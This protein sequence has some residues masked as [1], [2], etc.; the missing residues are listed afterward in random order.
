MSL[1]NPIGG[2]GPGGLAKLGTGTLTLNAANDYAGA[3]TVTAGTLVA[4]V[5]GALPKLSALVLETS[6]GS[7]VLL[8]LGADQSVGRLDSTS[9]FQVGAA[10]LD[11]G[12]HQLTFGNDNQ[13]GNIYAAIQG[14]GQLVKVGSGT[15]NFYNG[16]PANGPVTNYTGSLAVNGGKFVLNYDGFFFS[17]P[18]ALLPAGTS[19]SLGGGTLSVN[20]GSVGVSQAFSGTTINPGAGGLVTGT[21]SQPSQIDLGPLTRSAAG[22]TVDF[23]SSS[24]STFSTRTANTGGAILGGWAT[25]GGTQFAV[26]A[27]DGTNAGAISGLASG[28]GS[29]A[30]GGNIDA[31]GTSNVASGPIN[32]LRFNS[33]VTTTVDATSGLSIQTGGILVTSPSAGGA[34]NNGT[35]TSGNGAD[36]IATVGSFTTLTIGSRI[37]GAIGLTKSGAGTLAVSNPGNDFAGPVTLNAGALQV[38]ASGALAGNPI[39]INGSS[40][41]DRAAPALERR[42]FGQ[43]DLDQRPERDVWPGSHRGARPG[44]AQWRG[45]DH[46]RCAGDHRHQHLLGSPDREWSDP[47]AGWLRG[48]QPGRR[49]RLRRGRKLHRPSDHERHEQPRRRQWPEHCGHARSRHHQLRCARAERL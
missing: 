4:N 36:L 35:L 23:S 2:G 45:H 15:T 9:P 39:T 30:T 20:S 32:S 5:P 18:A 27:G 42:G 8:T 31:S 3:T 47:G 49:G 38:T 7:G 33:A 6:G 41:T 28:G 40:G 12:G 44:D 43:S 13:P 37:T 29:F 24:G 34:I 14:S 17:S 26:S 10:R 48:E 1:A 19:L 21:G 46:L 11:L 25:F 22:G 16:L